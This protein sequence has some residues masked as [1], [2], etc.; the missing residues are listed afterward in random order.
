MFLMGDANMHLSSVVDFTISNYGD[1]EVLISV[2]IL[3]FGNLI[4]FEG[5]ALN[6]VLKG[7]IPLKHK[8]EIVGFLI[9]QKKNRKKNLGF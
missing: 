1:K 5:C 8:P 6:S 3:E 2:S 9:D 4:S 7:A